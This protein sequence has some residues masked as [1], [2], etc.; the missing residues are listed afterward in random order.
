MPKQICIFG[1]RSNRR[2]PEEN[3]Y[4]NYWLE[5]FFENCRA[6]ILCK[7]DFEKSNSKAE[8][9][10]GLTLNIEKKHLIIEIE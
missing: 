10:I 8:L 3:L 6:G 9:T 2:I 5:V 1:K 4:L 7:Y